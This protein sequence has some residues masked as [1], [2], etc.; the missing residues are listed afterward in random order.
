MNRTFLIVAFVLVAIAAAFLLLKSNG[1]STESVPHISK[2][3]QTPVNYT[4]EI[5]STFNHDP[6]AFTQGLIYDKGIMYEGTGLYGQSTL[7]KVDYKT[8]TVLKFQKL[9]AEYFG[10]GLTLWKDKLIQLTWTT[11]TGFVYDKESFKLLKTFNYPTEGWG[12]THDAKKL[13]MSDGTANLYLL[14]PD[15]LTEIGRVKVTDQGTPVER[16]NE[17]EYVKGFVFANI[18]QT[19]RIAIINPSNGQVVGWIDLKG[20]LKPEFRTIGTDVLNGIA[21]DAASDQLFITGK[22]WPKL[23]QIKLVSK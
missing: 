4:Y 6:D 9:S 18:W 5:I 11:Q 10:E 15:S 16:L 8:G 22:K 20:I 19:D 23:F 21:Y 2:D 7:R 13:I 3:A 17:L 1:A 12:I 14:D